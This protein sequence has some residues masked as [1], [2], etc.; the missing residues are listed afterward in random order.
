MSIYDRVQSLIKERGLSVKQLERECDLA[1]ATI[2]RWSTQTPNIE[3]VRRVAQT[4]NVSIDY[5]VNGDSPNTTEPP[6]CDGVPLSQI[7]A[8]MIAM[9]RLLPE[10]AR[11]EVFDLVHFKYTRLEDG[12]KESIYS[13]YFDGSDEQSGPAEGRE[14]R[15]GTA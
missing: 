2:R 8:D 9:F 5:L 7:E 3:S 6:T 15:D 12:E 11:K 14:A 1:N 4:L 13:T 10:A